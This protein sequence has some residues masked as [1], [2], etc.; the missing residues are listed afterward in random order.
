[1]LESLLLRCAMTDSS[2]GSRLRQSALGLVVAS[3]ALQSAAKLA[4]VETRRGASKDAQRDRLLSILQYDA[5]P[6][7]DE[8]GHIGF[9]NC[10]AGTRS[11][12]SGHKWHPHAFV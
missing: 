2:A 4:N 7:K 1:M 11:D 6:L 10:S 12:T 5:L 3:R 9:A 8:R